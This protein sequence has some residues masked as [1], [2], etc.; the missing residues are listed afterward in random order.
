MGVGCSGHSNSSFFFVMEG[1]FI[2]MEFQEIEELTN[3]ESMVL[4]IYRYYTIKGDL[5]CC[6][7]KNEDICR[8][9]KL[10]D[11]RYLRR[12][13]KHLKDLGYISTDGGIKVTY[14]G[15][16]EGV[17]TL[18][19]EGVQTPQGGCTDPGRGV[20]KSKKEGVQ[21]PHKEEKEDKKR[22]K[23]GMTNFDL[24][25]GSLPKDYQTPERIDY[26]K[27]NYINRLNEID[28][29]E[30]GALDSCVT[31]IKSELN[32]VFKPDYVAPKK[33]QKIDFIDVL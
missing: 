29:N 23:E 2:P 3:T 33:E 15:I 10:K 12:I 7:L 30:G 21:T 14:L 11:E 8:M 6:S 9:V 26:I 27:N 19:R 5:H 24:L 1:I 20:Y 13:K 16:K 28:L 25:I 22:K 4:A 32:K 31:Y 18:P 17:Q